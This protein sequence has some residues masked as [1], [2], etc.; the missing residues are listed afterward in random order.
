[1]RLE[2]GRAMGMGEEGILESYLDEISKTWQQTGCGNEE[3][4]MC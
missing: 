1:M 2:E 4:G 3:E